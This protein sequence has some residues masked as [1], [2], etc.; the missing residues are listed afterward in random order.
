MALTLE[1]IARLSSVS[2]S[3]VSRVINGDEKVREE[4]RR[5][6]LDVIQQNNF[7][8]NMAARHL[9]AGR[10]NVIGLV[11][12][13]RVGTIFNDPYFSQLIQGVSAACNA[14][15]YS[16]MLWLAEPE[17]E[18]R[19]IRQI[20]SN[21]MVDGVVVSST[22]TDDPIVGSLHN[23]NVPFVL[24]GH[25]PAL[26][27]NSVDID[28][29]QAAQ[30]ATIHLINCGRSYLATI[31]GPQNQTAGQDRLRGFRLAIEQKGMIFDAA[32]A[33]EGNFTEAGGYTAM[34]KLLPAH[35]DAVFVASDM[36]AA[37][38]LRAI[39]ETSLKVPQDIAIVG[40]DDI[41]VAAQL[42]PPLTTIRQ[43]IQRMGSL[44]VETLIDVIHQPETQPRRIVLQPELI[45]RAS[46]GYNP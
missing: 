32:L 27:V 45:I 29:T 25:H 30:Q 38:A 43:P 13:A 22:L 36:M 26:E 4:T 8:P 39:R 44:A 41:P 6:V 33:A 31:S 3:T 40:F 34:Q 12:P 23:S 17:Y 21:G 28:N 46:C 20:V 37:G 1:D 19:M 18:R 42:N 10:T 11:I 9:A 24:I 14:K 16:V 5:H 2:R 15:E 35:P 7:H